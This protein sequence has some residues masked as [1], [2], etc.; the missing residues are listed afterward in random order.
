LLSKTVVE[1]D[2]NDTA[3]DSIRIDIDLAQ[4]DTSR[5]DVVTGSVNLWGADGYEVLC[6]D[7]SGS[8]CVVPNRPGESITIPA[9]IAEE[10]YA[11]AMA[12][13]IK[14]CQ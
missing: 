6:T 1:F 14:S 10:D 12:S 13:M 8:D 7:I 2:E 4:I 9:S 5:L 11:S 3:E